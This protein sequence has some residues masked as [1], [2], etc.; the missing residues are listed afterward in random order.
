MREVKRPSS[1][2]AQQMHIGTTQRACRS[3]ET[4]SMPY[5]FFLGYKIHPE[6][7]RKHASASRHSKKS[8]PVRI[9]VTSVAMGCMHSNMAILS[10]DIV[11]EYFAT[12]QNLQAIQRAPAVTIANHVSIRSTYAAA[13]CCGFHTMSNENIRMTAIIA[14]FETCAM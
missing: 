6:K 12:T 9:S 1:S 14:P 5:I 13:I 11:P 8:F 3:C 10:G 2:S 7:Y 4:C